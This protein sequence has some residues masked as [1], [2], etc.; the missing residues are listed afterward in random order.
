[1]FKD[2]DLSWWA[3]KQYKSLKYQRKVQFNRSYRPKAEMDTEIWERFWETRFEINWV[4]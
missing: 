3:S 1:M 2:K 4:C